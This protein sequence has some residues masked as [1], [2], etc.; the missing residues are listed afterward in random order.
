MMNLEDVALRIYLAVL[1]LLL[2]AFIKLYKR[3]VF[4]KSWS[5]S[6]ID[7]NA[8]FLSLYNRFRILLL[9]IYY[10]EFTSIETVGTIVA[11]GRW[12]WVTR[13]I[14]VSMATLG[15]LLYVWARKSLGDSWTPAMTNSI[16]KTNNKLI[17]RGPYRFE[18]HPMYLGYLLFLLG[19]QIAFLN[20][21]GF[22]FHFVT[23]F[24]YKEITKLEELN[25]INKFKDRYRVYR[26]GSRSVFG[27]S[28]P[29]KF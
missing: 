1:I 25:L 15:A 5:Q 27:V 14:G 8:K 2:E 20:Y 10:L 3:S 18:R 13:I 28:A 4:K 7:S 19:I 26:D 12:A 17:I 6:F 23:Y 22:L 29:F 9:A 16:A 24:V 11:F 21:L